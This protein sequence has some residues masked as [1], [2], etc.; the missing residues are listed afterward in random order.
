MV[1]KK[2]FDWM[3]KI[4]CGNSRNTSYRDLMT[5]LHETEFYWM[6][7]IPMDENRANDGLSLRYRFEQDT[8]YDSRKI[9]GPP[10]V[11]EVMVALAKRIEEN[12]FDDPREGD[13]TSQWFWEMITSLG[14]SKY[15][16]KHY[17]ENEVDDIL[18]VFLRREYSSNGEGGLFVVNK[19]YDDMRDIEIWKQMNWW[20]S[21][22]EEEE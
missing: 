17:D 9:T 16:G 15:N 20:A 19:P 6:Q 5:R 1:E 4:I 22:K 13:R 7:Y 3:Y 11:L 2:Y 10:S 14:L 12:I 8:G 18:E 21:E